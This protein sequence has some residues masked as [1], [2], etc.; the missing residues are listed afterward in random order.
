LPNLAVGNGTIDTPPDLF[1]SESMMRMPHLA[2]QAILPIR[3]ISLKEG[4]CAKHALATLSCRR[5][6]SISHPHTKI[7]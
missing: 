2:H 5:L 1:W 6:A 7:N 3:A 4:A